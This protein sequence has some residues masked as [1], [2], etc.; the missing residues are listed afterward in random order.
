MSQRR[1]AVLRADISREMDDLRRLVAEAEEWRPLL[2]DWPH[3][4]R[5]RTAGG[6]LH[7]FYCGVERIFRHIAVRMDEDLPSGTD[8]HIQLLQRMATDIETIRP[9]VLDRETA[10]RL[11]DYLRFRHLFRNIYG[12]DLEW[13]RCRE[14]LDDLPAT[15]ERLSQKLATFD[16]FLHTLE[17]EV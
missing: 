6:I 13:G 10:R 9:A 7:D 1:F 15:F 5:T 2:S 17:R 8:W 12:F 16:E 14:L 11:D 4:V 3:T